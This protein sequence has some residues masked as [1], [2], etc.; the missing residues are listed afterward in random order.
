M[1]VSLEIDWSNG[2][3]ESVPLGTLRTVRDDWGGIARELGLELI[4]HFY[5]YI[6]PNAENL[7]QM[8][9]EMTAFRAEVVR[10]GGEFEQYYV[11]KADSLIEAL[12]RLK[13]SEGWSASIG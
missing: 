12:E 10:R 13:R 8:L 7:D 3:S 1:S 6:E 5:E 4:P 2:S 9:S 11:E